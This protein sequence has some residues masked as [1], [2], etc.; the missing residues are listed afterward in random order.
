ML[1]TDL[2]RRAVLTGAGCGLLT[3]LAACG[4]GEETPSGQN[5]STASGLPIKAATVPVGGGVVAGDVV[6]LQLTKGNFTAFSAT[7]PH[8]FFKVQA[9]DTN[10][11]I[12][13]LG[14]MSHFNASDGSRIDGPATN[15]L[16]PVSVK[17]DG[18]NVV[19]A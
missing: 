12:T 4:S 16:T 3:L 15:G 17:L 8:Q 5:S 10:G 6:V 14:H 9:P 13:C 11:R 2:G 19:R 1:E 7:C 18:E